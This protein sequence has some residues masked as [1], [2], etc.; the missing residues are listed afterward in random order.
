MKKIVIA[1][2]GEQ[3]LVGPIYVSVALIDNN[4]FRNMRITKGK[5]YY[6]TKD[7]LE[8]AYID[9]IEPNN[10][11]ENL[12][13]GA[14]TKKIIDCLNTICE[15]WKYP[16]EIY[17]TID[18]LYLSNLE[19][20]E[21]LKNEI[22][23]K[24]NLRIYTRLPKINYSLNLIHTYSQYFFNKEFRILQQMYPEIGDGK[25]YSDDFKK[26]VER[27]KHLLIIKK[28]YKEV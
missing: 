10:I 13:I 7:K 14:I 16:V 25:T 2:Y 24:L 1:T 11:T 28:R 23:G 22:T 12:F 26:F 3:Y 6:Q 21:K 27:N 4:I 20:P 18:E 17:S 5:E 8:Q 19:F 9:F 15:F